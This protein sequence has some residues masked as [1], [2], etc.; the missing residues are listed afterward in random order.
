M[1]FKAFAIFVIVSL[2][3]VSTVSA[4]PYQYFSFRGPSSVCIPGSSYF[5]GCNNCFC[6]NDAHTVGCTTNWCMYAAK[7]PPPDDFWQ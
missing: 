7:I 6:Q 5:D 1:A 3:I 4:G 2:T